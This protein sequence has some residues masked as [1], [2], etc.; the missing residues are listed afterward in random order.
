MK[1]I[2]K[3]YGRDLKR[4]SRNVIAIVVAIGISV[5]P[6]LYAWFNIAANWDP[7]GNTNGLEVAV[8]NNDEGAEISGISIDIGD[9]IVT[10]LKANNQIGWT[11]LDQEEAIDGVMSGKYYAAIV[12]PSDF[13][14]K[15]ASILSDDIQRPNIQYYINEK[16]NAIAPKITDKGVQ[17]VQQTINQTF[18]SVATKTILTALDTTT[19]QLHDDQTRLSDRLINTLQ[20]IDYNL[21]NYQKSIESF[22]SVSDSV[23]SLIAAAQLTLPNTQEILNQANSTTKNTQDLLTNSREA[24]ASLGSSLDSTL[25]ATREA[26]N[27]VSNVTNNVLSNLENSTHTA[28]DTIA[29]LGTVSTVIETQNNQIIDMLTG[30]KSQLPQEG[31]ESTQTAIDGLISLIQANNQHQQAIQDKVNQTSSQLHATADQ[32]SSTRQNVN[33]QLTAAQN[34]LNDFKSNYTATI[35]PKLGSMLDNISS[36]NSNLSGLFTSA[37]GSI[38]NLDEIFANTN[39]A[40]SAGK[41][42]LQDTNDIINNTRSHI[43]TV[44]NEVQN[45]SEDEQLQ[46]LIEILTQDPTLMGDFMSAPVQIEQI[47]YYSIENY[48][49][50]MA[51]FYS[52][53][54]LWVGGVVLVAILKVHVDEDETLHHLTPTQTYL[55]RYLTFLTFGLLQSVIIFLGDLYFLE[56]QC[57]E[58][59]LFIVAGMCSSFVFTNIIY[60]LTVSFGDIGKALAVILLVIQIAGSG[61]TFPIEVTPAFFQAVNPFLPFTHAINAVRECV[62]GMYQNA[63]WVDLGKLL[64]FVP[65][66]LLLGLVLRRPLIQLNEFFERRLKDTHLM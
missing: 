55:G 47:S 26:Y 4:I 60:A 43:Q 6:A 51:P 56:I 34:S 25:N 32:S 2:F 57:K 8:V 33:S 36:M 50:A 52:V 16:K 5:L 18:V 27:T 9:E 53:L 63:Y 54:A 38:S 1:T 3:I 58:P 45:V 24:S 10:N 22:C 12:L 28:A 20:D 48:G 44:I 11:F 17:T 66:S 14:E 7:Y 65:I 41:K 35:Q 61:G 19:A 30:L 21:S 39:S 62:A 49:S 42:A 40:L 64:V 37:N 31:F 15:M 13:S 29:T 46:K 23:G 59:L